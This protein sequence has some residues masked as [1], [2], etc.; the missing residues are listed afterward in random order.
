[1]TSLKKQVGELEEKVES[2]GKE[3][4]MLK[5]DNKLTSREDP[6]HQQSIELLAFGGPTRNYME[7]IQ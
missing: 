1:M 7:F 6:H 2:Q 3:I 4:M 5:N